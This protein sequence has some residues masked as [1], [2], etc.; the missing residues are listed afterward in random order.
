MVMRNTRTLTALLQVLALAVL[1]IA[2]EPSRATALTLDFNG[3]GSGSFQYG[4]YSEDG[5]RVY[6]MLLPT[7]TG[8]AGTA[9]YQGH[10]DRECGIATTAPS[11][12]GNTTPF[13]PNYDGTQWLGTDP[14]SLRYFDAGSSLLSAGNDHSLIPRIRIDR[15]GDLFSL[16]DFVNV[17]G[18]Y[19]LTSSAGGYIAPSINPANFGQQVLLAGNLWSNISWLELTPLT[20]I[21]APVGFD[22]LNM[23]VPEPAPLALFLLALVGLGALRRRLVR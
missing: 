10:Y 22:N 6:S 16:L 14:G 20:D 19:A 9:F 7:A 8:P 5:F 3:P 21:G 13:A 17:R 11:E 23:N 15:S 18:G 1:A 2:A 4:A 12:C